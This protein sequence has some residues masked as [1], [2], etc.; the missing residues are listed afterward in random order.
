MRVVAASRLP[1]ARNCVAIAPLV[2][3][4][5]REDG[6]EGEVQDPLERIVRS[7]MVERCDAGASTDRDRGQAMRRFAEV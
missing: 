7:E 6:E 4:D 1:K 5:R 2:D 3:H